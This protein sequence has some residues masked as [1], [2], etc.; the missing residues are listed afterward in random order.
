MKVATAEC[1]THC[2]IA[3]RIHRLSAP[4]CKDR[5]MP[6]EVVWGGFF[7]NVESVKTILNLELPKPEYNL[8]GIKV[9]NEENDL[10]VSFLICKKIKGLFSS[11]ISIASSAGIGRGAVVINYKGEYFYLRSKHSVDLR[12]ADKKKV[13]LRSRSAV[14]RTIKSVESL[15]KGLPTPKYLKRLKWTE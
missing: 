15:I 4:Y 11:H 1:F 5:R 2:Q 9:Y 6:V 14:E 7:P 13:L 8:N 3:V 10:K 12:K